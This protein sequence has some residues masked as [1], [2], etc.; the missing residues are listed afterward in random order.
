MVRCLT[1]FT[2]REMQLKATN[3]AL[4][5]PKIKNTDNSEARESHTLL[6][7]I[8]DDMVTVENTLVSYEIKYPLN[9]G[10]R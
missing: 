5:M 4:R 9:P 10:G 8:Q 1:S 6:A 3:A 2:I 7:G